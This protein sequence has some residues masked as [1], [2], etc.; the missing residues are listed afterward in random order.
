VLQAGIVLEGS[1][2][3]ARAATAPEREGHQRG[4]GLVLRAACGM[5]QHFAGEK[6]SHHAP[7]AFKRWSPSE[8]E[9][10]LRGF[11]ERLDIGELSRLLGRNP[12]GV[13]RR[14]IRLGR[15]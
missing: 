1:P 10:L 8:E 4:V 6:S 3:Y 14:L 2:C 13:R 5:L 12:E 11:A 7:N 9:Q 15:M